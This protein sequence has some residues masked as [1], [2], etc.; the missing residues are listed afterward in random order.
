MVTNEA[1]EA[2]PLYRLIEDEAQREILAA[3]GIDGFFL[4]ESRGPD[5]VVVMEGVSG[6]SDTTQANPVNA[7]R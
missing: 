7:G 2:S 4:N 3:T 1:A 6:W 5:G